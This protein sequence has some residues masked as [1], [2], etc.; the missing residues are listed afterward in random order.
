MKKEWKIT[1][2]VLKMSGKL[3]ALGCWFQPK[4][5]ISGT[6]RD[7]EGRRGVSVQTHY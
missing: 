3:M 2:K 4:F 1:L 5:P 6:L 7:G